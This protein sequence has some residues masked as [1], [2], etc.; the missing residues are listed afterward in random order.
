ME[1]IDDSRSIIDALAR[2]ADE[3]P[4]RVA[5]TILGDDEEPAA[6]ATF[7]EIYT[8]SIAFACALRAR[9]PAQSRVLLLL[10]TGL[11]FVY[12]FF[13]CLAASMLAVPVG[14]SRQMRKAAPWKKLQDIAADCE[15]RVILADGESR[16]A[17]R[18]AQATE[19][20][21]SGCDI[22]TVDE[23]TAGGSRYLASSPTA[24]PDL[25]RQDIAFLQYTSGSTG[26]PKGVVLTHENILNNQAVI[27]GSMGMSRSTR[28]MSWLP[29]YH[30]MGLSAILQVAAS[31]VS[32]VLLPPAAFIR[33]PLLWLKA[34]S[35][36]RANV[37]GGPNFGYRLVTDALKSSEWMPEL[38]LSHWD[39][40]FCGAEPINRGTVQAFLTQACAY[41]LNPKSFYAC[42]GMAEATLHISG[43]GKGLGARFLGVSRRALARDR[44]S[45][46][47]DADVIHLAACGATLVG[48]E[49]RIVDPATRAICADDVVGE[50]WVR[51]PSIAQGYWNNASQTA[52]TFRARAA[53]DNG[54]HFLRTG[55]LGSIHDGQLYVTGRLKDMI[56]I[57]GRNLY[58]HDVEEAVQGSIDGLR[59]DC[60]AAFS[61]DVDGEEKL[62]VVQEVERARRRAGPFDAMIRAILT[63][64]VD[65]FDVTPHQILLV[66]PATIEKTSSGKIAR[67][68]CRD[69]Y[70]RDQFA[71]IAVWP[72]T[73]G[74]P[75]ALPQASLSGRQ[76]ERM[77]IDAV[78]QF[79]KLP[80][81]CVSKEIPWV[82]LGFD[83]VSAVQMAA[84]IEAMFKVKLEPTAFWDHVNIDEL[85]SYLVSLTA[86]GPAGH[87][88]HCDDV[89]SAPR[90]PA[91]AIPSVDFVAKP[92]AP[93]D[94]RAASLVVA[95][96]E[97]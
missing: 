44:L 57:R 96:L 5:V 89:D 15:A 82:E 78:S 42:Y 19:G 4:E 70:L 46:C 6:R 21:F 35:E 7:S 27:A 74:V 86:R 97:R 73:S 33:R 65:E 75:T 69:A 49:L 66:N 58:P 18:L 39:V 54:G 43:V 52:E 81:S 55:D 26:A 2:R 9:W 22:L 62:V 17:L 72:P 71:P 14:R 80:R 95:E 88:E 84:K 12:A 28:G 94:E 40:A 50:I 85:T 37:S 59:K 77:L 30:D 51:G 11:D 76:I 34:I 32:L 38:D 83:S 93:S 8:A 45:L 10:P 79:Q 31:G 1:M 24:L 87:S 25:R 91:S 63:A 47:Q 16:D 23:L 64:V 20:W 92:V 36:Y 68:R 13:G 29:L 56:I 3:T 53:D 60:G 90:Q 48:N 61:I 67:R 41:G